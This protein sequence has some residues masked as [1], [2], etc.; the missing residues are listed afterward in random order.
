MDEARK[1]EAGRGRDP[2]EA[3][4]AGSVAGIWAVDDG[5]GAGPRTGCWRIDGGRGL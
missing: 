3:F 1:K 2:G 4:D 5:V